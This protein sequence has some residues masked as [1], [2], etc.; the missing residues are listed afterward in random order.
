MYRLPQDEYCI[1][2]LFYPNP[3]VLCYIGDFRVPR[4]G[5]KMPEE[6]EFDVVVIG[7]GNAAL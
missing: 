2:F 3:I 5:E 6:K 7:A 1:T 4:N